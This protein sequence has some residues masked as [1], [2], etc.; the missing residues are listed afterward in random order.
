M[1]ALVQE[2]GELGVIASDLGVI[3]SQREEALIWLTDI[4]CMQDED[5]V[6]RRVALYALIRAGTGAMPALREAWD[7][8][9]GL[10]V[11]GRLHLCMMDIIGGAKNSAEE[12]DE[13]PLLAEREIPRWIETLR[14]AEPRVRCWAVMILV[15]LV[16]YA[17]AHIEEV[18]NQLSEFLTLDLS[19]DDD[20]S[21]R[22]F[23][24]MRDHAGRAIKN[25]S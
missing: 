8:E 9:H 10:L 2:L 17:P 1:G 5:E 24:A 7:R 21:R 22:D 4:V 11:R 15:A 25:L 12:S 3:A 23:A 20:L 6:V 16:P 14:T 13:M 18:R 19:T